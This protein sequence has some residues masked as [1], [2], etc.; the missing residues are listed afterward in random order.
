MKGILLAI[1]LSVIS[2]YTM[3]QNKTTRPEVGNVCKV[4]SG[5]EGLR[6]TTCRLGA[7]DKNEALLGFSGV[8]HP[9]NGK[10]F[11]AKL[12]KFKNNSNSNNFNIEYTIEWKGKQYNVLTFKEGYGSGFTAYMMPYGSLQVEH[13]LA[14]DEYGSSGCSPERFLTE[15]LEQKD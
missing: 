14:Y 5:T 3:A 8:D 2:M 1:F 15:Y 10:I 9:W 13:R 11:K 12:K 7:E 6:I 4:Y